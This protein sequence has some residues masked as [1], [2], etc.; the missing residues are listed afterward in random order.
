[1]DC[2]FIPL[3]EIVKLQPMTNSSTL[4]PT[5]FVPH[6]APTSAL[7]PGEAGRVLSKIVAGLRPKAVLIV[8]AHWDTE[9]PS[10]TVAPRLE[11]IHDF[12]GFP[13]ALYA[14]R[15]PATGAAPWAMEARSLLEEAG[16][17]VKLDCKRGLDHGAWVPL[18]MM[19]PDASLPVFAL[20]LQSH[21]GPQHHFQ[22]GQALAPLAKAGVLV[23][24]SGNLTHNLHHFGR[25]R[26][27]THP[28]EYVTAFQRWVQE[29][30]AARDIEA[31]L[32]Y[33]RRAPGALD[34]HPTDEHLLPLFVALGA[35]GQD[36]AAERV[37]DGIE[38]NIL[39]M[40]TYVFHPDAATLN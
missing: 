6:G 8:S 11:T 25:S 19:Y 36:F 34:A 3:K 12:Y 21:L 1:M 31:L 14:I 2:I 9:A 32:D 40:D 27:A 30:M 20:S 17:Q 24:G 4:L 23:I 38:F 26:G 15:Y 16:Y 29:R 39:A 10:L 35:A 7:E 28:P 37:Y 5:L 33:R 22:L 18:R 13:Q